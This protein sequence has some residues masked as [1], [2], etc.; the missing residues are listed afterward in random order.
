MRCSRCG[1]ENGNMV[2]FC[3]NCGAPVQQNV[4]PYNYRNQAGNPYMMKPQ[5]KSPVLFILVGIVAVMF[6]VVAGTGIF[7]AV[8][9]K[10]AY[11]EEKMQESYYN[12]KVRNPD[13]TVRNYNEEYDPNAN[14]YDSTEEQ[15]SIGGKMVQDIIDTYNS[16]GEEEESSE[17]DNL[18]SP[19]DREL[20]K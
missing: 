15:K 4:Q 2:K 3:T 20:L 7:L 10:Q 16:T 6:L 8:K 5:K 12:F 17:Y 9:A 14:S 1:M 11:D 13:G 18:G 19:W